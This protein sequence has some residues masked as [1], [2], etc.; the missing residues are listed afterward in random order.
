MENNKNYIIFGAILGLSLIVSASIGAFTFYKLRAT[1]YISSTGSAKKAVVSDKAKWTSS[2]NRN[3]TLS[4]LK[5]GYAKLDT[6]LKEVKA[7]LLANGIKEENIVISPVYMNEVYEQYPSADKKYNLVQNI[8]VNDTDV[9]KIDQLSKNTNTLIV[10][11]GVLFSTNSVEYYYSKLPEARVELLAS[12]VEDAKARAGELARAGGKSIGVLKS[13]SSGVVQVMS[14]N[15]VEVSDY[16]M[17][18]TSKKWSTKTETKSTPTLTIT[19]H[20]ASTYSCLPH[21]EKN[22]CCRT[23]TISSV[24]HCAV[25]TESTP[26]FWTGSCTQQKMTGSRDG[27]SAKRRA[28]ICAWLKRRTTPTLSR[29]FI[30]FTSLQL[31]RLTVKYIRSSSRYIASPASATF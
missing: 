14:P 31:T 22:F 25:I 17:Y 20:T 6:D 18:D 11:K 29:I 13:A 30:T 5:G 19:G 23:K 7:F 9:N 15:S 24:E 28:V 4:T 26:C 1:D 12:A 10:D 27:I 3:V 21:S 8:E 2:I 16:G